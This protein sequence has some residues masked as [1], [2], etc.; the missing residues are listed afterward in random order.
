M[1][2][3][4]TVILTS[5]PPI[6]RSWPQPFCKTLSIRAEQ[7]PSSWQP[8]EGTVRCFET[9]SERLCALS[10]RILGDGSAT[11]LVKRWHAA[12]KAT[13]DHFGRHLMAR[14]LP[15]VCT[16]PHCCSRRPTSRAPGRGQSCP[17]DWTTTSDRTSS[18][19]VDF[20]RLVDDV[21]Q[22]G[23]PRLVSLGNNWR[24]RLATDEAHDV[25]RPS[26]RLAMN[27]SKPDV[28]TTGHYRTSAGGSLFQ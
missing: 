16:H 20:G 25:G 22:T 14:C 12:S 13:P 9:Q 8:E 4:W 1:A 24:C 11:S 28:T 26:C 19:V 3:T 21:K 5:L 2:R 7:G 10:D 23:K 18:Q 17:G 6:S 15:I 27:L